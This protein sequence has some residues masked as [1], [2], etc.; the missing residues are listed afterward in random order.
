MVVSKAY[1]IIPVKKY[2]ILKKCLKIGGIGFTE[3]CLA[4]EFTF[5]VKSNYCNL[6]RLSDKPCEK[7]EFWEISPKLPKKLID[8][9][10]SIRPQ[11][12]A[13]Y[14]VVRWIG[15]FLIVSGKLPQLNSRS[16]ASTHGLFHHKTKK[17][18]RIYSVNGD[19][20]ADNDRDDIVIGE[21]VL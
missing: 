6:Q 9:K 3:I 21:I 13:K 18:I 7:F 16:T 17:N 5:E 11:P 20:S 15:F 14:F 8:T 19:V 4:I 1:Q 12:L 10:G 2:W